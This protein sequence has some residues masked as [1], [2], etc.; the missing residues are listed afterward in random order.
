MNANNKLILKAIQKVKLLNLQESCN[1]AVRVNEWGYKVP[2]NIQHFL[3]KEY[4]ERKMFK[5]KFKN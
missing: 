3:N 4:F 1:H 2:F 5:L